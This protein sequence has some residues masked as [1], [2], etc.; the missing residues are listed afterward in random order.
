MT[1]RAVLPALAL[2]LLP[3]CTVIHVHGAEPR[4]IV[5]FGI[6]QLAPAEGARSVSYRISGLGLVPGTRGATLGFSREEAVI[7]F[8]AGACQ[9]VFFEPPP[10]T[11][12]NR[13]W[14]EP[15]LANPNICRGGEQ[16]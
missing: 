15:L 12:D 8:D 11:P 4:S 14:L 1:A 7:L 13:T 16:P 2:W 5:R 3:A 10:A 9:I 6:L